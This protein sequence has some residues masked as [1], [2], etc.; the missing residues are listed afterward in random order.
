VLSTGDLTA[1]SWWQIPLIVIAE[2]IGGAAIGAVLGYGARWVLPRLALPSVGLYPIAVMSLMAL[3]YGVASVAHTSGFMAVYIAAILVGATENLPHRRSVVGFAEGLAWAA[4]IGLFV[5]LGLLASLDAVSE[6][7]V[8][9]VVAGVALVV[10]ARPLSAVVSLLPFRLPMNWIAF[11]SVAGLRGAVPIVFAAI[12][13][14]LAVPESQI[15]FDATLVLVVVL[16]LVQTPLLP[17]AG[18]QLDVDV[19]WKAEELAVES[20]PMDNIDASLLGIDIDEH[21]RIV[22]LYVADLRLPPE[23]SVSLLVRDGRGFVPDVN[24]RFRP[25]DQMLVVTTAKARRAVVRRLRLVSRDGR[26]AGWRQ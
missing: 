23:A 15:V 9:A 18:R 11:V 14:G 21:S 19:G 4:Q 13:L 7:V 26:L 17:W 2:I 16:T 20:A 25:R 22:G 8:P 5:M 3:T 24:T 10:V 12:P 1:D 6:S